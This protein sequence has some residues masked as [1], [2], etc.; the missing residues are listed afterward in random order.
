MERAYI[1]EK[2]SVVIPCFN[3]EEYLEDC[4]AS[5]FNQN[6]SL[7]VICV[8]NGS[9]D[10]TLKKLESLQNIFPEIQVLQE[11]TKGANHA[12]NRGLAEANGKY[13]QFLDADDRLKQ[14]KLLHQM[15][16]IKSAAVITSPYTRVR[17]A[18]ETSIYPDRNPWKGLFTTRLGIT[19]SA[20]FNTKDVVEAGGWNTDLS[21]SQ[22]YELM[23][24]LLKSGKS[25]VVDDR[26]LTIVLDRPSGQ[27]STSD[28]KAR[29]SNYLNLRKA[30]FEELIHNRPAIFNENASFFY[31]AFF[32]TIH[33]A[34][35]HCGDEALKYYND[36][37]K[38]KYKVHPSPA[39]GKFFFFLM[40]V[41]GFEYA[42]SIKKLVKKG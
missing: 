32:D 23:F 26:L 38:G 28:P 18:V 30:I 37:I 15:Q 33:I 11:L 12:R 27:I 2:I 35:P 16:S 13:V 19:S 14:G 42:E 40:Q 8:D 36:Y 9:T 10:G 4:I 41:V 39:T 20:L 24:R 22:E 17:G 34:Y 21:S 7:Q 5:V 31:Q 3:V 29:W 1:S 25:I 6:V